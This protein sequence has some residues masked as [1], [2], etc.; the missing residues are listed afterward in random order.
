MSL[1]LPSNPRPRPTFSNENHLETQNTEVKTK[2]IKIIKEF[3]KIKECMSK[4]FNEFQE[5]NKHSNDV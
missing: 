2:T 1:F 4:H 5:D 3:K